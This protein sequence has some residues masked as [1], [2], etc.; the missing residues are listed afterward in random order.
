MEA[1]AIVFDSQEAL[2]S[3]FNNGELE[4]DFIAV[5]RYQGPKANGM[6]ELHGLMP[7]L[8]VLQDRGFKVAIMTDGRMSGASGKVVSAI[9]IVPEAADG[10][11]LSKIVTG[12]RIRLDIHNGNMTLLVAEE[13]LQ[14]RESEFVNLTHN[15]HGFGREL[16]ATI[17]Q[18]VSNA[19]EGAS[20]FDIVGKERG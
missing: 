9:H 11:I 5:V 10:G 17:R 3:A 7:P 20:I 6:P 15:H 14:K 12:D 16:F 1:E 4:R 2:Q 13:I 19:E 18:A 8:G